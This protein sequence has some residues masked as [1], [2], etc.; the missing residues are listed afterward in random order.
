MW[1]L[2]GHERRNARTV[3]IRRLFLSVLCFFQPEW[4]L[5]CQNK[6]WNGFECKDSAWTM[7][8]WL[9][10]AKRLGTMTA[11]AFLFVLDTSIVCYQK[12]LTFLGMH[13][14]MNLIRQFSVQWGSC[15]LMSNAMSLSN[16]WVAPQK[17]ALD[18]RCKGMPLSSF[19]LKPMQR[20]TRYPLLIKSV[21]TLSEVL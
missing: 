21:S 3:D 18:P 15:F 10:L 9:M 20:I 17:L 5:Y 6:S 4:S 2:W 7:I 14:K 8:L 19:L 1:W 11:P 16:L 13:G 12:N